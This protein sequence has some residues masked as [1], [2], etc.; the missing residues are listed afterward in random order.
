MPSGLTVAMR[1]PTMRR[2]PTLSLFS[3]SHARL[4]PHCNQPW[5]ADDQSGAPVCPSCGARDERPASTDHATTTYLPPV[6]TPF[7]SRSV[8]SRLLIAGIFIGWLLLYYWP[9]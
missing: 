9:V 5:P 4:C 1:V 2:L 3:M 6:K 7:R 8:L